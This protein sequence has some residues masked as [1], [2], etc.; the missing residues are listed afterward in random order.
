MNIKRKKKAWIGV[1]TV[2]DPKAN[3]PWAR[4]VGWY[5]AK[6]D[7]EER[8]FSLLSDALRAY[9]DSVVNRMGATTK[10]SSLNFPDEWEFG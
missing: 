5:V 10:P 1:R 9:D 2:V 8:A 7:G 6:I 3:D 4:D